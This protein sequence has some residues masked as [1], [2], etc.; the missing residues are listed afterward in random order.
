MFSRGLIAPEQDSDLR[1]MNDWFEHRARASHD[2]MPPLAWSDVPHAFV[3][4][5]L[6][7]LVCSGGSLLF[8][9]MGWWG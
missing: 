4:Y 7:A 6:T 9:S 8:W 3:V 1:K 2:G 5:T